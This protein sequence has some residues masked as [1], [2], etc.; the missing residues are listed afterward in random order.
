MR[1]SM[2]MMPA[3]CVLGLAAC[4][5]Q[6]PAPEQVSEQ[7]DPM[8]MTGDMAP[9]PEMDQVARGEYLVT[10]MSCADCHTPMTPGPD[11]PQPDLDR[12]LAG[13]PEGVMVEATQIPDGF[14]MLQ[15]ETATAF[16][17]P[18]G[19]SYAANLTSDMNTGI[20]M[21][22][23]QMFIDAMRNGQHMGN[24]R[25]LMPPMPWQ[26]LA[27]M[28]DEDLVAILAYLKTVPAIPNAVGAHVH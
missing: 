1:V 24:E 5:A 18:W 9:A 14:L 16:V 7:P 10:T 17:G 27:A 6:A 25:P 2:W 28:T 8:D 12:F 13:H 26:S 15:S 20:G 22:T 19:V 4:S 23:D 3:V 11:G 21:Y